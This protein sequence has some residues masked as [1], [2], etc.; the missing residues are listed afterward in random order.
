MSVLLWPFRAFHAVAARPRPWWRVLL[1]VAVAAAPGLLLVSTADTTRLAERTLK[2]APSTEVE[3]EDAA[4]AL[5][6]REKA[7]KVMVPAT[8][9][10]RRLFWIAVVSLLAF[11]LLR[12]PCP[13]LALSVV[14]ATVAA[15]AA[16]LLLLDGIKV[17]QVLVQ[18]PLWVDLDNPVASNPASWLGL[19]ARTSPM[20]AALKGL[21]L[22][23]L[24]TV[25]L[26]VVG[27]RVVS[28]KRGFLVS[29]APWAVFLVA[30]G[31]DVIGALLRA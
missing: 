19:D 11:A 17:A 20:G 24:W 18:D 27:L 13:Q 3:G 23:R 8:G 16:P 4:A 12:G 21:D 22:F 28:G 15:A 1:V 30:V 7:L 9:A 29:A 31:A 2:G 14:V 26:T 5:D 25:G 6:R 10:G